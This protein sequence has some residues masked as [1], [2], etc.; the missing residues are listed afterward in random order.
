MIP[1]CGR[2]CGEIL[3]SFVMCVL[4]E[5]FDGAGVFSL[6]PEGFVGGYR[7][8]SS[9]DPRNLPQDPI[10]SA[11]Q[12]RSDPAKKE[13]FG[14]I[15]SKMAGSRTKKPLFFLENFCAFDGTGLSGEVYVKHVLRVCVWRGGVL[16]SR[17]MGKRFKRIC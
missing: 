1:M 15:L 12:K 2:F 6:C 10:F 4:C 14:Q 11:D 7:H 13:P 3:V 16:D 17:V 8:R 9:R 5:K